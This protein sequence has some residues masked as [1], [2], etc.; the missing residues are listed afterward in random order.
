MNSHLQHH[1][2]LPN[3]QKALV[4]TAPFGKGEYKIIEKPIPTPKPDQI[5]VRIE[6]T[7]LSPADWKIPTPAFA[8]WTDSYPITLGWDGAGVVEA[9]GSE[10]T[11]YAKGDRV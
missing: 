9:V 4:L 10:V 2:H 3:M 1:K 7:G 11:G 6:A 5:L 8:L